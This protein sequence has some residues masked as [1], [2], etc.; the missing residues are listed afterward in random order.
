MKYLLI[1]VTSLTFSKVAKAQFVIVSD[2]SVV[3]SQLKK[4]YLEEIKNTADY[5]MPLIYHENILDSSQLNFGIF[6]F[7]SLS[8]NAL[9]QL[10]LRNYGSDSIEVIQQYNMEKVFSKIFSYFKL[11]NSNISYSQK[12]ECAFKIVQLLQQRIQ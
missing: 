8:S 10:Y 1:I 3:Y 6:V 9:Q 11:N 4:S 2:T 5:R 12:L 7:R